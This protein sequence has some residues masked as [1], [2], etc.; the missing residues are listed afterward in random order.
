MADIVTFTAIYT[1]FFSVFIVICFISFGEHTFGMSSITLSATTVYQ[2]F[3]GEFPYTTMFNADS[4]VSALVL[5]IFVFSMN[6]L[7]M[8]MYTAIVIRQ[9]NKLQARMLFLG[10]SVA[11]IIAKRTKKRVKN[12]VNFLCCRSTFKKPKQEKANF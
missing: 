3:L 11:V 7:I 12:Y 4:Q 6:L 1:L 2:M 5:F 8:N 10:E 9:Y